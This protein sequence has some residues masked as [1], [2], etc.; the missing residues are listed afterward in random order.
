MSACDH[1]HRPGIP[2]THRGRSFDGL[3]PHRGERLC[4][5]CTD[6]T[7]DADGANITVRTR[8][9]HEYVIN[10]TRDRDKVFI[11]SAHL[12]IA[13]GRDMDKYVRRAE[14]A[15]RRSRR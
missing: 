4:P 1:C 11:G 12:D 5:A 3:T 9:A 10:T 8:D 7:V 13:D 6:A 14:R 2:Y 15:A